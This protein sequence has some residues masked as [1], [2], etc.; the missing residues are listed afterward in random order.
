[1][2]RLT[3]KITIVVFLA[4]AICIGALAY[5]Q[6]PG[7]TRY[8]IIETLSK[9]AADLLYV[10]KTGDTMTGPLVATTGTSAPAI[11]GTV[12]LGAA[13][14]DEVAYELN[15]TTNKAAGNDTGLLIS[16]TDTASPGTSYPLDIKVGGSSKFFVTES[17]TMTALGRLIAGTTV[18]TGGSSGLS[19]G[20][21][22]IWPSA[23]AG[24]LLL[25]T[26]LYANGS[27]GGTG[28]IDA[29]GAMYLGDGTYSTTITPAAGSIIA[30]GPCDFQ[31]TVRISSE[32]TTSHNISMSAGRVIGAP[33]TKGSIMFDN[34]Y[35]TPDSAMIIPGTLSN[36]F[37]VGTWA[38]RAKD[39]TFPLQTN[40][41]FFF[42]SVTDA[43]IDKTQ[44]LS[45]SHN[46]ATGYINSGKGGVTFG[47]AQFLDAQT[48]DPCTAAPYAPGA[49]FMNDLAKVPCYCDASSDDVRFDGTTP[50]F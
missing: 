2:K 24:P 27:P 12:T 38:N 39:F 9:A 23:Q 40:P 49:V 43:S 22:G 41:T 19:L 36:A 8:G 45:L 21:L 37:I 46:Q 44:W 14:G 4:L 35:Q 29:R 18:N 15:Y 1:M 34:S 31:S 10:K 13:T 7:S 25:R 11:D 48:D 26:D 16:M 47:T 5:A 50:C 30:E 20:T 17:G 42:T 33:N 32:L 6:V 28:Y 3:A